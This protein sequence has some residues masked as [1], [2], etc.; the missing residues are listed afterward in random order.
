M[1]GALTGSHAFGSLS[2]EHL[3]PFMEVVS[4]DD[5]IQNE[6]VVLDE[7]FSSFASCE[8]AESSDWWVSIG[9]GHQEHAA[10]VKIIKARAV[11]C[12]VL[13]RFGEAIWCSL[14]EHQNLHG[15]PHGVSGTTALGQA[16]QAF[17]ELARLS[18]QQPAL[19]LFP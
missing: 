6:R 11:G 1:F 16:I 15:A 19:R 13:P 10:L 7:L 18:A 9:P 12:K 2:G 3:I 17:D 8:D 14:I 5:V 4:R